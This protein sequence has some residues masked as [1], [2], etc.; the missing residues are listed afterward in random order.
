M[1][2]SLLRFAQFNSNFMDTKKSPC[3]KQSML[4][5]FPLLFFLP[6]L[7]SSTNGNGKWYWRFSET[8]WLRAN[9]KQ[10]SALASSL[11]HQ[12]MRSLYWV[13]GLMVSNLFLY[14]KNCCSR[15]PGSSCISSPVH[16][17][18]VSRF[19]GARSFS[20]LA[21]VRFALISLFTYE[22]A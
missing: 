10:I 13:L 8:K 1:C 3:S 9:V 2:L 4:T 11:V 15:Y 14:M 6:V 19:V 12:V 22:Y 16:W 20:C 18:I 17:Y 21:T 7:S 5:F